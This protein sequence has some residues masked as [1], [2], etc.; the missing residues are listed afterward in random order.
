MDFVYDIVL[1][2][3]P[4]YYEFYE[5]EN[6]DKIISVNKI[7]IYKV[8]TKDY[9]N[10]KNHQVMID[11]T[12]LPR[13]NKMFLLA[14]NNE[15]IGIL[16]NEKGEVIKKS[17]LLLDE[18]DEIMGDIDSIKKISIKYTIIKNNPI[19]V[20]NRYT[21]EKEA[22]LNNFFNTINLEQDTYLLKYLYYEIYHIDEPNI[23]IVYKSLKELIKKDLDSLYNNTKL[24][25]NEL[26]KTI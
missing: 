20:L 14:S 3:Q 26:K 5:W 1:N 9:L 7:P 16:I 8:S 18:A 6:K 23:D 22:Y 11:K 17:S 15:I 25:L 10:I 19:R 4:I 12:S 2:F 24:V 13:A 21:R